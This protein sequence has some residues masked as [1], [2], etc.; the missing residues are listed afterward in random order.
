MFHPRHRLLLPAI[1]AAAV[2]L[3]ASA[4]AGGPAPSG[5]NGCPSRAVCDHALGVALTSPPGWRRVPPGHFPPHTLVWYV[6]PPLGLDYNVRLLLGPDGTT[7]DRNDVHAAA[8][9]A[10]KLIAGYHGHVHATQYAVRF[11]SAPGVLIRGLP[12]CC[13]P[14]AI[15]ILAHHGALYSIIAPGKTL[16]PDQRAALASLRFIPRQGAF[17]S[18]SPE[19]PTGSPTHHTI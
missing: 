3:P 4:A 18:S 8:M 19:A 14:E 10:D 2:R 16:G 5:T 17:P 6:E 12:G 9:A 7:R 15:T 13:G 11:G 1:L